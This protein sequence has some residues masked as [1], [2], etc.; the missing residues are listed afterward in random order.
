MIF[1]GDDWA[2]AHHDVF[3]MD[4]DGT[5]LASRRLPEGESS[6]L[7]LGKMRCRTRF[8]AAQ[9]IPDG[10]K[11]NPAGFIELRPVFSCSLHPAGIVPGATRC[12]LS[13]R[14]ASCPPE[15]VASDVC[16]ALPIGSSR[17]T[18]REVAGEESARVR[19]P[20]RDLI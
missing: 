17:P 16:P 18:L 10:T 11:H 7:V 8:S 5:Q 4:P 9:Y 12:V 15:P 19:D 1:V 14:H 6:F 3:V 20:V 13:D 2:E